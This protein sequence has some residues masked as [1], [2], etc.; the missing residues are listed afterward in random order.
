MLARKGCVDFFYHFLSTHTYY[1]LF[2]E[3]DSVDD[4]INNIISM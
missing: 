3:F 4:T 2:Y 1:R